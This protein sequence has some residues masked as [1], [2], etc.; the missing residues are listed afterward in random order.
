V[1]ER[2]TSR[3]SGLI[4]LDASVPRD[5]ESNNDVLGPKMA[6]R[7]RCLAETNGE[8]WRVPPSPV[9][10]WGIPDVLRPWVERRLTPHPLRS[11]E[12]PVHLTQT[13]TRLPSVFLRSST[14]STLYGG[15][16][17]RVRDAGW[18]C[19]DLCGGHYPMLTEPCALAKALA[20][21]SP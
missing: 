9:E 3:L 2:A 19:R 6:T 1:A 13:A 17:A 5:G 12:D 4:Y 16:M 14:Q 7:L 18:T 20:D 8:G 21:L 11:L 15:L 10:G